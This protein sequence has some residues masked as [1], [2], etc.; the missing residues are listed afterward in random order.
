MHAYVIA[1][2]DQG[3]E[4]HIHNS[5]VGYG[6]CLYTYN[7]ICMCI[8]MGL[9]NTAAVKQFTNLQVATCVQM[10]CMHARILLKNKSLYIAYYY[11]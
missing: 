5:I 8:N 11:Y 10:V 3:N 7:I 9:L 6:L 1:Y 4:Y 2:I